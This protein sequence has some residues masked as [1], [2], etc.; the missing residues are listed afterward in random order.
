MIK[1][2]YITVSKFSKAIAIVVLLA[3]TTHLKAQTSQLTIEECYTLAKQNYPLIKKH[4]LVA[5]STNYSLKNASKLYLPQVTINGQA[6][7]QSETINFSDALPSIPNVSFPT[8]SKD[9]YR[10]QAEVSQIIY[11]AGTVKNQKELIRANDSVLQQS[12]EVSL[13]ALKDRVNQIYF[14]ILL[15]DKQ[16]KQN[17][18][19]KSDL[20]TAANKA[21][22]AYQNGTAFKSNVDELKAELINVNV[23]SIEL[24]ANRKAFTDMLSLLIGQPIDEDTELVQPSPP[25]ITTEINRPE[26][27]LYN[28]REKFF[29]IQEKQLKSSYMPKLNAF[30]QGAY[31]RPTLNFIE[32][33]FGAWWMGGIHMNWSLGDLYSLKNNKSILN[34]NRQS[35]DIDKETFLFNTNLTLSQ[36]NADIK[37][38]TELLRQDDTVIALRG[39]VVQSAKAQLDN[40]VITVHEYISKLNAENIAKQTRI[41]HH[42]Q[43]LQAQYNYK[44]TSGN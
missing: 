34:L 23:S 9:Q 12:I 33:K 17:E 13:N 37:K 14:S 30:V 28:L 42:I 20:Q 41:L 25:A 4:D 7:Y 32:N 21:V 2:A 8:L 11:D 1:S 22:I 26:L 10:I 24:K 19:R 38:Y 16:L 39:S 3:V 35:L 29:D 44:N 6:S 27:K 31:G 15:M 18:L 36:Q 43:L 40:G 5:K